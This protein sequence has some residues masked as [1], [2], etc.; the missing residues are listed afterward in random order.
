[1]HTQ[2]TFLGRL[3]EAMEERMMMRGGCVSL[4]I[5]SQRKASTC[6]PSQATPTLASAAPQKGVDPTNDISGVDPT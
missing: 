3:P 4:G 6:S 2:V 5:L 1:M